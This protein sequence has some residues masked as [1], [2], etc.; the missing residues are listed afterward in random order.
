[1]SEGSLQD[2]WYT[3]AGLRRVS[4]AHTARQ[5]PGPVRSSPVCDKLNRYLLI[6]ESSYID[7]Q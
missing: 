1:M 2:F 7:N 6:S 4:A 3:G 5:V